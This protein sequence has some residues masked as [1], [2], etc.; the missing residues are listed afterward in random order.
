MRQL[1]ILKIPLKEL[2]EKGE[3]VVK[4][5]GKLLTTPLHI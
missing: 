5:I 3:E 1:S 4:R 2:Y